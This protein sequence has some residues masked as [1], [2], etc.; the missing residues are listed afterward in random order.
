MIQEW[1]PPIFEKK[2]GQLITSSAIN[3]KNRMWC[4]GN[5]DGIAE[6]F[7]KGVK[8]SS[9]LPIGVGSIRSMSYSD[10]GSSVLIGDKDANVYIVNS[11]T[12]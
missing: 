3:E 6:F 5:S 7:F 1:M 11:E 8:N 9:T 10:D 4:C 2:C 12:L